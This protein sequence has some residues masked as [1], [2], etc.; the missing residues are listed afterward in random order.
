MYTV[1]FSMVGDVF[2]GNIIN[3]FEFIVIDA[4]LLE[5]PSRG[6]VGVNDVH[7]EA[8]QKDLY[9]C[10]VSCRMYSLVILPVEAFYR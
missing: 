7:M 5:L 8:Y 2:T 6:R 3:V 10:S 9:T 4:V 1:C